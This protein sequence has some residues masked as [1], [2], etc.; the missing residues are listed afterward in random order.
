[1]FKDILMLKSKLE[2]NKFWK[3]LQVGEVIQF[4]M[5]FTFV[6]MLKILIKS[7]NESLDKPALFVFSVDQ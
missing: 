2:S 3:A 1:M 5:I 7:Y 4:F 6:P